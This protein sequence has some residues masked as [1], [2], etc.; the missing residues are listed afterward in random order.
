[1]HIGI[2]N[3]GS[4]LEGHYR[5]LLLRPIESV[6]IP[7]CLTEFHSQQGGTSRSA[8]CA[9]HPILKIRH[10]ISQDAGAARQE[11]EAPFAVNPAVKP[12]VASLAELREI[13]SRWKLV[14]NEAVEVDS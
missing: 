14:I 7:G 3:C 2:P 10:P 13:N 8:S 12:L 6:Y 1:V 5:R 9:T 4:M 11:G